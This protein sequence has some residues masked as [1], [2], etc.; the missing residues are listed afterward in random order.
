[1][2]LPQHIIRTVSESTSNR[3][4]CVLVHTRPIN[5][6]PACSFLS[7]RTSFE[8]CL[9]PHAL[10]AKHHSYQDSILKNFSPNSCPNPFLTHVSN[11]TSFVSTL[12]LTP[13][14]RVSGPSRTR[15]AQSSV[16]HLLAPPCLFLTPRLLHDKMR[17]EEHRRIATL[18]QWELQ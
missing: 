4:N 18:L 8:L 11:H 1:M 13:P 14:L 15:N 6:I 7:T 10:S 12:N 9:S 2:H 17:A 3:S 16:V 5:P